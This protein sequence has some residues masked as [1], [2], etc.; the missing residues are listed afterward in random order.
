MLNWFGPLAV[1]LVAA[2]LY[3]GLHYL[4]KRFPV[5]G[6]RG[7]ALA[8]T[9]MLVFAYLWA[10]PAI[11]EVRGLNMY[12]PFGDEMAKTALSV[13]LVWFS[14]L[15][16][17]C[18]VFGAFFPYKTLH[19]INRFFSPV[20]LVLDL[21]FFRTYMTALMGHAI[22]EGGFDIRLPF[23][24]ALLGFSLASAMRDWITDASLPRGKEIVTLLYTLPFAALA[25]M[26][27][28]VPQALLGYMRETLEFEGFSPEHRVV[29]YFGIIIPFLVFHAFKDKP[30]DVKRFAMIFMSIGA[31]FVFLGDWE[32]A[33]FAN[34]TRWPL[35][36]CHTAMFLVPLCLIFS[37]RRLY[38]FCLFINVIGAFL[39]MVMPDLADL[40][41]IETSSIVFWVNHYSAFYMP[42]LLVALKIFK[43]PKF[44]EW[45]A[46][47]ASLVVYY[48]A[49]LFCNPLF[50][51]I[52]GRES[53]FFYLNG[54]F[55][56]D[57]LG[58]WAER[59][60]EFVLTVQMGKHTLT[61][62]P[63]YQALFLAIFIALTVGLWFLYTLLF[64]IWD[65]AEDRRERE[66]SYK[67]MKK[68]LTD[69][70]GGKSIEEPISGDGSPSL[71]LREFCKK[72]GS[73]KHYSV[74][75]VSLEVHG[76]EIF[77]FLGPNGAGKSTIIKSI[78]GI[79]PLTSGDIEICGYHVEKQAVQ[80]KL[81]TGF[82][83]DHYALY[84]NLTGREYINYIADLYQVTREYR[85]AIIE[86]LV[87]RFQLVDSFDNQMKTY[88]H[89]MKQKITIMAALVH[90]PPVWILDEP[91]TGLDPNSIH[92]VKMCMKEHAAAGNI[93]FFSSHIIDVVEK[94]CDRIAI[95]KK[96]KLRACRTVAELEAEGIELERFYL[97][98]ISAEEPAETPAAQRGTDDVTDTEG[99]PIA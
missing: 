85:D 4:N 6:A 72:Y 70:L 96:G 94:I 7:V 79:Q 51:S 5:W 99:A 39:A 68:E 27:A 14:Y 26:P 55:I 28:Y 22:F 3:F 21:V 25:F 97:D 66:R 49:M 40:N 18:A 95:I 50:E 53:D 56:V 12:S 16:I 87:T 48:V 91:L 29:L 19:N 15:T 69:F 80:A 84:E 45:C 20:V 90:N 65:A 61:F 98:V 30:Y 36:L 42:I 62:M 32:L 41:V 31:L 82:V 76:G 75:H 67:M 44:R 24:L 73:N 34:P 74:D 1:L 43:R 59:T 83:P 71:V 63:I 47:L 77:G 13:L 93:V 8:A 46:A 52:T 17:F 38:N 33:D 78:V 64:S 60:Q 89:G 23:Y 35:H 10:E 58:K 54:D 88:S 2:A 81:R 57:N 37:M 86:K 11:G 92:E 9:A